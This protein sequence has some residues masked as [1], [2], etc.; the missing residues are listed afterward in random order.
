[1]LQLIY[2][3]NRLAKMDSERAAVSVCTNCI[4]YSCTIYLIKLTHR[5]KF[6]HSVLSKSHS[7]IKV[8][9]GAKTRCQVHVL[10]AKP[11]TADILAP[12]SENLPCNSPDGGLRHPSHQVM[13]IEVLWSAWTEHS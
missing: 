10:Y 8:V 6:Y 5:C 3:L 2:T 13:Q 12:Q 9:I 4:Q 11:A 7:F 1:M